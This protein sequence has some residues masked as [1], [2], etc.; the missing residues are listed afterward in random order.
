M[1][2]QAAS[3]VGEEAKEF[4]FTTFK[5]AQEENILRLLFGLVLVTRISMRYSVPILL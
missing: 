2:R 1:K 4:Y 3:A 5:N